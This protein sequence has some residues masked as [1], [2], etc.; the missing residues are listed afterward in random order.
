MIKSHTIL[1]QLVD[2]GSFVKGTAIATHLVSAQ[3]IDQKEEDVWLVGRNLRLSS[4][5]ESEQRQD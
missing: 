3:I 2:I 5:R 4:L 1:G